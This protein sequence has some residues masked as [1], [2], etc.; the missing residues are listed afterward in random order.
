MANGGW[1]VRGLSV[2]THFLYSRVLFGQFGAV[3]GESWEGRRGSKIMRP[4][5]LDKRPV[6]WMFLRFRRPLPAMSGFPAYTTWLDELGRTH[7]MH[8][9]NDILHI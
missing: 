6:P 1:A 4:M 7:D 3:L 8:D 2:S 5:L 9:L